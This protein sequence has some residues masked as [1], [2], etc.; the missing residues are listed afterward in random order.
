MCLTMAGSYIHLHEGYAR[1]SSVD[2]LTHLC[3][4]NLLLVT[5]P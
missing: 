2:L 4:R 3:L 1:S 5:G